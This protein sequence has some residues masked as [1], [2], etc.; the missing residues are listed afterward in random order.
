MQLLQALLGEPIRKMAKHCI[1]RTRRRRNEMKETERKEHKRSY[2]FFEKTQ[3]KIPR[4]RKN[5]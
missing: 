4:T 2:A 3:I 1:H 5:F